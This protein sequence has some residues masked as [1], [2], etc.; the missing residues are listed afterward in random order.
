MTAIKGEDRVYEAGEEITEQMFNFVTKSGRRTPYFVNTGRYT[1]GAQMEALGAVYAR[2]ITERF[3]DG[4]DVIF[5]PAYK[6]IPLAVAAALTEPTVALRAERSDLPERALRRRTLEARRSE[7]VDLLARIGRLGP[8]DR[9]RLEA[10]G[11]GIRRRRGDLGFRGR[12][13]TVLG[14]GQRGPLG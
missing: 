2:T 11:G 12:P 14:R 1:T 3:G 8:E 5:G 9:A 7:V 6:G 13:A 4:F 10:A